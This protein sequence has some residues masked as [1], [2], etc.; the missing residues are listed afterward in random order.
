M[1]DEGGT[2]RVKGKGKKQENKKQDARSV[3]NKDAKGKKARML[4][5]LSY[6]ERLYYSQAN[7]KQMARKW[8]V[9]IFLPRPTRWLASGTWSAP[10]SV[11]RCAKAKCCMFEPDK[12]VYAGTLGRDPGQP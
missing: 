8:A 6:L 12:G 9:S 1:K 5:S 2:L 4:S 11:R 10:S 7:M 3:G